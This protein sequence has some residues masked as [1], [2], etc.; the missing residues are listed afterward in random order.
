MMTAKQISKPPSATGNNH[1]DWANRPCLWAVAVLQESNPVEKAQLTLTAHTCLSPYG[2]FTFDACPIP[3]R[4]ARPEKPILLRPKDMPRRRKA[5]TREGR[6]ALL[7][8]LSHIELN[9]IDLAWDIILRFQKDV[10]G[11]RRDEFFLDWLSVAFDEARHFLLLAQR[12]DFYNV[13]YGDLPA[14]DGLWESAAL[15][16]DDLLARLAVVPLVLEARGLDV[17][18]AMAAQLKTAGDDESAAALKTIHDEEIR[19]VALGQ[20]W[21]ELIC[22]MRG[23]NARETWQTLVKQRFLGTLKKP[24][25]TASRTMAGLLP[26]WYEPLA[27]KK[28]T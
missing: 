15:T 3:A 9:A 27:D 18:P 4:P 7:H 5:Q 13:A 25:N 8:A 20:K 6:I 10:M 11:S 14:H 21:F 19:H 12:L 1:A 17:T 16:A 24:F 26:D 2:A 22:S 28:E 23:L